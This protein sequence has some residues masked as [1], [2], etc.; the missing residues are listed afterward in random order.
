MKR[1]NR[2]AAIVAVVLVGGCDRPDESGVE[3]GEDPTEKLPAKYKTQAP[4][5]GPDFREAAKAP[6][7]QQAIKDVGALLGAPP[8][9]LDTPAED[10]DLSGGVSFDVPQDKIQGILRK[11]HADFL[12]KG[13][14]VF[15]YDQGFGRDPDKVGLLPTN[16]KYE[17]IA[18]MGTNGDNYNISTAGVI[19]WLKDLEVDQPFVLTGIGFDYLEGHFT[20]KVKNPNAV[21]RRMYE[22]CPDIVHQGVN[23]VGNL[24]K[25]V[26]K[27][28][29][30]FWW[31]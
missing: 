29:L 9:P 3:S 23:S 1:W 7:F 14:Y 8:R 18:A 12:A 30:Y 13:F 6:A 17:V 26:R 5:A 21:A 16:D 25:E 2:I 10:R 15:R 22:F 11:T 19:A 31:D 20:S 28:T 4:V 27:D 24:A